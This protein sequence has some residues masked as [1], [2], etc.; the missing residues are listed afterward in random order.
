MKK[1]R[2]S[3]LALAVG[4]SFNKENNML[5]IEQE[6]L[7]DL[8]HW[9]RRYCDRRSTYAPSE[10]NKIYD[11]LILKYPFI[12]DKDRMD[13]TL[14]DKGKFFPYCQD[15]MFNPETNHFNAVSS[16]RFSTTS[17]RCMK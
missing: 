4:I 15:G 1:T 9:A 2:R 12:Q 16:N 14:M 10:F 13:E 7:L 3:Q 17:A 5:Q 11:A 8:L 6:D